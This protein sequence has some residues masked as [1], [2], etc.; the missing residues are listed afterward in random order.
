MQGCDVTVVHL[1]ATLME[2]QL[3][4]DGGDYLVG[5]MEELG[6]TRAAR[7]AR[8]R[9]FWATAASR[10]WRSRT[11]RA[12]RRISSSWPPASAP[13]SIWADKAGL[14]VN[15]GIV[16]NDYM[17]TS[18]PDIFAVGECVEHRGV[19]Y[20][21]VAP[22]FEQ[23]KVLAATITGNKGPTYTG[24]VQAAKLKIM[25]V[26]VFS[27]GDWSEPRTPSQCGTKIRALGIY[28]KLVVRDGKLAGVILVG[29]T[30]DSHRYM[31][32]LRTGADL[33]TQR[34]HLLF[35][36]AS[37][38][39]PASTSREMADSATVCGCV[40]VTK[41]AII[42]AIHEQRRQHAVAAQGDARA[43]APGAA[44][45]RG[46]ARTCCARSRPSSRR[47]PRRCI[48]ACVPF[49]ED[50]LRD[51]LRSQQLQVR[52]GGPRHL[53]QRRGLRGLQAR[54]ELHARHA[55]V[56]RP[57]RRPIGAVHQRSR[58]REHPEGRHVLGRSAHP[59]RRHDARRA[60]ADR[61]RG[62]EVPRADGEDHRQP[63]HRSA[64]RE[65]GGSAERVGRPR[66]AVR[67][68][69]HEGRAH[70]E[71]VRRHAILPVRHAGLDGAGI[72]MERRFEQLFTPHKVKM[73]AV[74]CPR[75]CAEATVKDIG[76]IGQEGGWQVVVGGAAGKSVRKADLLDDGRNHRRG[77]RSWP[78][79]SSSTTART[80][81]YLER[82][83]D[84]VERLGIEKVRKDTVYAP[85]A[86][87][88]WP[89]RSAAQIQGARA[90]SPG[91]RAAVPKHPTQ[92]I[93]LRPVDADTVP[94]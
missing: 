53:R 72:E 35:P 58:A 23:G 56:R 62:R 26:D 90:R 38:A 94:V 28:K 10:A 1:M 18:T 33:T 41:G 40:G 87:R 44:A 74:G 34:R 83:Y 9:P 27:A 76:L 52:A 59:R 48:C 61:R 45:A 43:R 50:K 12:S 77:A 47:R 20:G 54:A 80:A 82:T 7:T 5:K 88:Q 66:H 93:P 14:A 86:A 63:A 51:I 46:C 69:L 6:I 67:P 25:G 79:C 78:S 32:W 16:V 21:L 73:A 55:L 37:S 81:N 42:H 71:D 3:D 92:F 2:R 17:E 39:T 57:R 70:G 22:L 4:P 15:R 91:S 30:S 29:D 89:A 19:C 31:D 11:A 24:T 49:A 85:E 64:R 60:A 75:N 13:T 65:E 8:R 36:A 84:F 68:G